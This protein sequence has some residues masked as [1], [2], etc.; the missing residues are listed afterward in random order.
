MTTTETPLLR[1][2]RLLM[3]KAND[4]S[5]GEAEATAFAEKVQE[6]LL[7]NGLNA[8]DVDLSA[9]NKPAEQVQE[10]EQHRGGKDFLKSPARRVLL[11][12][13]CKF[14]MCS[15]LRWGSE[16]V[17]IIG[18]KSNAEVAASMMGYLLD[19][20]IRLSNTYA[21][22]QTERVDYRRGCMMRLAE[23][24]NEMAAER[25]RAALN[26][27]GNTL[28]VLFKNEGALVQEYLKNRGG[29]RIGRAAR[30]K[31][32]VHAMAGRAAADRV[33]LS[34]QVGQGAAARQI[35]RR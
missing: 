35:G 27:K 6:L 22:R 1:K 7:E 20:T 9:G 19:V 26:Q 17:V 16:R 24:L 25:E 23:R 30:V 21:S 34:P 5:I 29:V 4:R 32:G 18:K 33:S 13:V 15:Y 12:A 8:S 14:Y 31:H 3:A 2:I 11:A 10:H 28:P